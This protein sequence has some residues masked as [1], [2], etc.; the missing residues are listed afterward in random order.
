MNPSGSML[1]ALALALA[2]LS[3]CTTP[4]AE[5]DPKA[6]TRVLV[7]LVQPSSDAAAIARAVERAAG[8]PARYVASSS[9]QWHALALRC[10]APGDCDA[11]LQRL[12][13]D[14]ASFEAVQRDERRRIVTP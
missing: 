5:A 10:G 1:G 12:R 11:A 9:P 4:M 14:R 8:V 7:K 3:A 2:A 13:A 6:E